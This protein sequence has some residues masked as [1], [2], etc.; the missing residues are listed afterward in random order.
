MKLFFKT[1]GVFFLCVLVFSM[2]DA[3]LVEIF[4]YG[5]TNLGGFIIFVPTIIITFSFYKKFKN[6]Q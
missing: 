1:L 5:K 6:K 2:V 4:R 3:F